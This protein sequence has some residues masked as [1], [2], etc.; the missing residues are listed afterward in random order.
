MISG[1]G[2][3]FGSARKRLMGATALTPGSESS[4]QP[5]RVVLVFLTF[6]VGLWLQ[7][8]GADHPWSGLPVLVPRNALALFCVAVESIV[9]MGRPLCSCL[10]DGFRRSPN[11]F[12]L[13]SKRAVK[14]HTVAQAL[15]ER[16]WVADIKG[17]LTVQVLTEYLQFWD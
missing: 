8:T 13:I 2:G 12:K 1:V 7:K 5:N 9:G 3:F 6:N 14:Q 17:A 10:I 16:R 4:D 15:T 11:L